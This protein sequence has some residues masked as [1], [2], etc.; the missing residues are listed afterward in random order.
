M[1]MPFS[2]LAAALLLSGAII[3]SSYYIPPH[4]LSYETI[5][6]FPSAISGSNLAPRRNGKLLAT[7]QGAAKVYEI[8]PSREQSASL[9]TTFPA[10][11]NTFGIVEVEPDVF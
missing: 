2:S 5:Y 3:S 6:K 10:H 11:Q 9:L 1:K 7:T 4:P 8:G